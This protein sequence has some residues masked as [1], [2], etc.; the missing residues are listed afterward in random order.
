MG[1]CGVHRFASLFVMSF[2]LIACANHSLDCSMGIWHDDCEPG[3][4]AYEQKKDADAKQMATDAANAAKDDA[5]CRSYGFKPDTP[6]YVQCR[7]R[8]ADQRNYE[9]N[10]ERSAVAGRL[11]GRLPN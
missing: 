8:L 6:S 4:R 7:T 10:T 2:V 11:L 1:S 5:E 3:S 9:T